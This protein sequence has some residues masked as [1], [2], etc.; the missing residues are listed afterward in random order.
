LAVLRRTPG[1][2]TGLAKAHV[3]LILEWEKSWTAGERVSGEGV[4]VEVSVVVVAR[5]QRPSLGGR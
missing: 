5:K 4:P 3:E 2:A 1:S